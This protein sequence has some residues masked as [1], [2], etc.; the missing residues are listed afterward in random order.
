MGS[1]SSNSYQYKSEGGEWSAKTKLH[2]G[3]NFRQL[4]REARYRAARQRRIYPDR[5]SKNP[6]RQAYTSGG[7]DT[8][9]APKGM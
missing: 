1:S 9:G 3:G 6:F 7:P 4:F 8:A 5:Y 2:R